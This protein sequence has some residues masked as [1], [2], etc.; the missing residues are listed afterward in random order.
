M[1]EEASLLPVEYAAVCHAV[2][3]F[4]Q[5]HP[6]EVFA[7][8]SGQVKEE[9]KHRGIGKLRRFP[10]TS[11]GWIVSAA[12]AP[13]GPVHHRLWYF[14][15]GGDPVHLLP[16]PPR[17]LLGLIVQFGLL[18]LVGGLYLRQHRQELVRRQVSGAGDE[19]AV[20]GQKRGGGPPSD[21]IPGVDV[22]TVVTVHPDR[23]EVR[24]DEARHV[25]VGVGRLVHFVAPG[26]PDGGDGKQHRLVFRLGLGKSA[27][28]PRMPVNRSC[29]AGRGR[30]FRSI[31]RV[32]CLGVTCLGVTCLE[33]DSA[34]GAGPAHLSA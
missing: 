26:A 13:P 29:L 22:R 3:G 7:G 12:K 34:R 8:G 6:V 10:K 11:V 32:T 30:K 16:P 5:H 2:E 17:P 28:A 1:P 19:A 24:I 25:R 20:A 9:A 18:L 14:R 15:A 27:L 31:Q 23:H 33:I 4:S 21:V